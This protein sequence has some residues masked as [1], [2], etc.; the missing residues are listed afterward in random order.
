MRLKEGF[1]LVLGNIDIKKMRC[2]LIWREI[3]LKN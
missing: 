3:K 2:T 1:Q